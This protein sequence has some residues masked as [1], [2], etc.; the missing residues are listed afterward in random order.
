MIEF[1]E[2]IPNQTYLERPGA[3]AVILKNGLYAIVQNPK[4]CFLLGGGIEGDE[5]P[6][7]ALHREV[8]E[9]IGMS[10]RIDKK[11]GIAT[12]H[13]FAPEADLYISKEGH[14]YQATLL[15]QVS[16]TSETNHE[17][18]WLTREEVLEKLFHESH[19]WAIDA[20]SILA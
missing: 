12:Q 17:L 16:E 3:Y 6:E 4:S 13:L 10:I 11:I 5:T 2:K 18:L 9:E 20:A 15:D 14:F 7:E 19:R 8:L 1:G